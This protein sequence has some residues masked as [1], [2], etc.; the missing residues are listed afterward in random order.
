MRV[1]Y[2]YRLLPTTEQKA[3][4]DRWLD[5]LRLQYNW[6]LGERFRWWEENR[7]DINACPLIC[8][9]PE[10]RDNPD[11]YSQKRSLVQLKQDR[12]WYARVY[13]QVLQDCVTRVKLAFDRFIKGDSKG[14]RS[15]QPRFKGKNRYRSFTYTQIDISDIKDNRISLSKIGWV[16]LVLHRPI[17]DRFKAKTAIVTKKSDGWYVTITLVD[18]SV[19][20]SSIEIIPTPDNSIA[21]DLGLEKFAA[22]DTGEFVDIPQHFRKSEAKLAKLQQKVATRKKGSRAR[23]LLNRRIGRLH[24]QIA[25]QRKQFHFE[26]D[27]QV[28]QKDLVVFVEDLEV[29]NMSKRC[30]PKQDEEGNYVANR[31]SSKSGLNK[32]IADAGWAQFIDILSFKAESAGGKVVKVNPKNTS[33]F[34]SNCL[35]VVPKTL[36]ERW[37]DYDRCNLSIDRDTN[38]AILINKVGLGVVLTIKR[39]R[40]NSREAHA[41]AS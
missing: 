6:L 4:M 8:H 3:A 28:M 37:H 27:K 38:S 26:N 7:C 40:R 32:S 22:L 1:A 18:E 24:Q 35:N 23:K 13:S 20:T 17:P 14:N 15:G 11:Y 25:R 30:K 10:L 9:L 16:K 34:C 39:S 33:Q 36:K 29:K 19:P 12:P 41:V 5:M 2:Q 31:Q 21:L